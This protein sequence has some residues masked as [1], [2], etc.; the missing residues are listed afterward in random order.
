ML[1]SRNSGAKVVL[2]FLIDK[3]FCANLAISVYE[4][5]LGYL[6]IMAANAKRP[7]QKG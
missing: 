7:M 3:C 5:R 1:L 4:K 2:F 6:A